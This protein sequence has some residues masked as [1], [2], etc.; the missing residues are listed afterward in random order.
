MFPSGTTLASR[1]GKVNF[2]GD[3]VKDLVRVT[4]KMRKSGRTG[5]ARYRILLRILASIVQQTEE[6][7]AKVKS[8]STFARVKETSEGVFTPE[9]YDR[10]VMQI[11]SLRSLLSKQP[12][13][14]LQ[15]QPKEA[16]MQ[17]PKPDSDPASSV[18]DLMS[19][20]IYPAPVPSDI[21]REE[22]RHRIKEQIAGARRLIDLSIK[23]LRDKGKPVP[24]ELELGHLRLSKDILESQH[25]LRTE[26]VASLDS[27]AIV[28][29]DFRLPNTV[30]TQQRQREKLNRRNRQREN[31][32]KERARKEF[33]N[34]IC[35]HHRKVFNA[36]HRDQRR[37]A[38]NLAKAVIKELANKAKKR[39]EREK[40]ANSARL[41][42]LREKDEKKYMELL[43][44][45]KNE[46]LMSLLKQTEEYMEK[47]GA[48]IQKEQEKNK[49]LRA[50]SLE[51]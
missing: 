18:Q 2:T 45:A 36:H 14:R 49:L 48:T 41:K 25:K 15:L 31:K 16:S 10:L 27:K 37:L 24:I 50:A 40:L 29:N 51:E 33:L 21:A 4:E 1:E 26:V 34:Q 6:R 42:A 43:M 7:E 28:G 30:E 13:F 39:E 11:E 19:A 23:R 44:E 12:A 35:T 5:D 47:I 20:Q 9:Q 8:F 17:Q 22:C 46:R 3:D 32:R 38:K